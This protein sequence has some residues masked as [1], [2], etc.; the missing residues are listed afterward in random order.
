MGKY[1][2]TEDDLEFIRSMC[3]V[4]EKIGFNWAKAIRSFPAT[5]KE[6]ILWKEKMLAGIEYCGILNAKQV[7]GDGNL[8]S[9]HFPQSQPRPYASAE[10]T[11]LKSG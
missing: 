6:E 10:N 8:C 3:E 7:R 4:S 5:A 11:P 1:T 2:F 9:N